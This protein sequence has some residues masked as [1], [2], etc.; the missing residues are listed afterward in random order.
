MK[1]SDYVGND[2][3]FFNNNKMDYEHHEDNGNDYYPDVDNDYDML[4]F[5][6]LN[7]T[8]E[9]EKIGMVEE[10]VVDEVKDCCI[11]NWVLSYW[12]RVV[13]WSQKIDKVFG[14]RNMGGK[15]MTGDKELKFEK[16]T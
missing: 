7:I 4:I 14:V 15:W 13:N 2:G 1:I 5:M 8:L 3:K 6:L 9:S 11:L 10:R 16:I 12:E